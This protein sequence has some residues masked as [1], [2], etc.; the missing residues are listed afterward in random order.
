MLSYCNPALS[1]VCFISYSEPGKH[2]FP[3]R[4][5]QNAKSPNGRILMTKD[6]VCKMDIDEKQTSFSSQYAGRE[7]HF[8]SEECKD[9]FDSQ[10]ERYATTAA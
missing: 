2:L 5:I 7:Y 9:M 4:R 10:P 3:L 8:C 1:N 6:P